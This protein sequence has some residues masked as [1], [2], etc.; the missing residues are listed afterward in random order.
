MMRRF[1]LTLAVLLT[2]SGLF[3]GDHNF[4]HT[5]DDFDDCNARNYRFDGE[6]GVVER[7]EIPARGLNSLRVRAENG[8]VSVKGGA[9]TLSIV[10][11]KAAANE[12]ALRDIRVDLSGNELSA[13]GPSHGDWT[14]G[15]Q[16]RV[17]RGIN[18]DVTSKNGPVSMKDVD[19]RFVAHAKNGPVSLKNVSGEVDAKTTNGPISIT[20]GAGTVKAVA[21]NGPVSIRLEGSGWQGGSLEA[22]TENGPLSVRVPRG[23]AT[24]VLIETNGRG[25]VS[26]NFEGCDEVRRAQREDRWNSPRRI[27][28]GSGP[29]NVHLSVENGPLTIKEA[30]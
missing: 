9:D 20:G 15:Y 1:V 8:P 3:A 21:T 10:V 23:Y 17:P 19:G 11:C 22:S 25:P 24:G 26:C 12:R 27:E 2:A 30:D 29:Q 7:V 13:D 18:L 4:T 6:R 14:V 16:I 28:L 5:S